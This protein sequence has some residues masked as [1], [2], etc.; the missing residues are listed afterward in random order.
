MV[1]VVTSPRNDSDSA[2]VRGYPTTQASTQAAAV[3]APAD[4]RVT[5]FG[6]GHDP[7]DP[8]ALQSDVG[9]ATSSCPACQQGAEGHYSFADR[10]SDPGMVGVI[11]SRLVTGPN[12]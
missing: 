5:E 12:Q 11:A 1:D 2:A 4:T 8:D 6:A 3:S 9:H 10:R 7:A